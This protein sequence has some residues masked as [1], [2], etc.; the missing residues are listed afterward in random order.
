MFPNAVTNLP[1]GDVYRQAVGFISL[2]GLNPAVGTSYEALWGAGGAYNFDVSGT[3]KASSSSAADASAGTGARTVRVYGLVS[4]TEDSEDITLNGQTQVSLTK[5]FTSIYHAAITTAG[6]GGTNAG[7][8]YLSTGAVTAG[9]PD[10]AT[11]VHAKILVGDGEAHDAVFRVPTGMVAY[12]VEWGL[13]Q[14]NTADAFQAQLC[15]RGGS[16]VVTLAHR[17]FVSVE[18]ISDCPAV[19]MR[20]PSGW[21]IFIRAKTLGAGTPVMSARID[22][23]LANG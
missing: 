23:V 4:G 20:V 16:A 11:T 8:I 7:D 1:R 5:A 2:S 9:V 22:I 21:D 3:L 6:S 18:G 19:P 13:T 12:V 14:G 17:N 10:T 15:A